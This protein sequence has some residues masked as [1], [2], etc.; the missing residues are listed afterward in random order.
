[1][2]VSAKIADIQAKSESWNVRLI[3][4]HDLNGH[5]DGMQLLK[6][7]RYIYLAHL[8]TSPMALTI[9]DAA[10]PSDP[11]VIKQMP[12]PDNTHAHKVQIAGD[13]LIQNQERPYFD[14]SIAASVPNEAG[15]RIYSIENPTEPREIGRSEE[16]TSELQSPMYLVCRLLLE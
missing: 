12:H 4:H 16:H 7:G 3:G 9:L 10:D 15:I 14:K 8:G 13:V 1:M 11:R 6:N 2:N 5:G